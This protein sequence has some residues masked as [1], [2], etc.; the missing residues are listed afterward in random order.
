MADVYISDAT[1]A[2]YVSEY[3]GDAKAEIRR[4]VESNAP[5]EDR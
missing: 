1:F 4:V 2:Q 5:E 3:G